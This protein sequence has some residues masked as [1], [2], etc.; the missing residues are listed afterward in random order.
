MFYVLAM[1]LG[2][3]GGRGELREKLGMRGRVDMYR[4]W[5]VVGQ[6]LTEQTVHILSIIVAK[7]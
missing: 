2:E 3:G 1:L 4:R 6:W 5:K 7:P